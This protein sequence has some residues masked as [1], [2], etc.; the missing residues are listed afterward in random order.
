MTEPKTLVRLIVAAFVAT[1]AFYPGLQTK[2]ADGQRV[3]IEIRSFQFFPEVP[4]LQPGDIVI[5]VNKDIVPHTVTADNGSW[6]SGQIES[7]GEWQMVVEDDLFETYFCRFHLSMTA[8]LDIAAST[9]LDGQP[10][11]RLELSNLPH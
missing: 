11:Q 10:N 1:I 4:V 5:W 9:S 6:D 3:V 7:G 8:R 2:A